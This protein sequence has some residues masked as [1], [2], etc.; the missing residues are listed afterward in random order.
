ML[1]LSIR[2]HLVVQT[3]LRSIAAVIYWL[4]GRYKRASQLWVV[5]AAGS[6]ICIIHRVVVTLPA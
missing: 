2:T 6:L 3:R 1:R 4:C 5:R